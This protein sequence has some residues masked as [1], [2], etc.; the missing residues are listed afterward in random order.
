MKVEVRS[1]APTCWES[2]AKA[3]PNPLGLPGLH[4]AYDL[5]VLFLSPKDNDHSVRPF[6]F[7]TVDKIVSLPVAI[8]LCNRLNVTV[9]LLLLVRELLLVRSLF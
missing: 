3:L 7:F 2:H 8:T 1:L 9:L 5:P 4:K 6:F